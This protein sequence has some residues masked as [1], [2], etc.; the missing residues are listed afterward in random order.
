M[1]PIRR[2]LVW[3]VVARAAILGALVL[4]TL[5]LGRASPYVWPVS[6]LAVIV[7]GHSLIYAVALRLS[8]PA[9]I[10][11]PVQLGNDVLLVTWLVYHT[12]DLESP[13]LALYLIVIFAASLLSSRIGVFAITLFTIVLGSIVGAAILSGV[14]ARADGTYY[15]DEALPVL[16]LSFAYTVVA[17]IAVA[18]LSTHLAGRQRRSDTELAETVRSLADL[19]AF[20]ERVIE[21]MRS[22]LITAGLDGIIASTNK[23]AEEITGRP[24][25]ELVG[26]SIVELFGSLPMT[27]LVKNPDDPKIPVLRSELVFS[28]P[29]G[30][31]V[32]VGY[33]VT[34]LTAED[35]EVRGIVL[36]F[37]DL[38]EI[39]ELEQE[40][41]RR[42]KLAALGTM[43][44][45]L[46]HEIRNPLASMRGS[47][48][49]LAAEVPLDESQARLMN[50]IQRESDRLNRTVTAF[51]A[52]A[53]PAPF[54]A[55][56]F[57]L[58]QSLVEAVTL[59]RNS[60]EVG[61]K[62]T[63]VESYPAGEAPFYGDASQIRQIFWNLARNGLKAMPDGG[64]LTVRL[65]DE[66]PAAYRLTV[67]DAGVGM[68]EN[69]VAHLFEPF[70][71]SN[72]GGTGL[73]MAIVYQLVTEHGG[74][75]IVDSTK[76]G[77]TRM[78]VVLPKRSSAS[79]A[80]IET[81][82][83]PTVASSST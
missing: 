59:L 29:D 10:L 74:R 5:L 50:I 45:G 13:F 8:V 28:R 56:A 38:T 3:L 41:R 63:L 55:T 35:G 2:R 34:P 66:S 7:S 77:G 25:S 48:Q 39:F 44:A 54:R 9:R 49:V 80:E 37:Q 57:D 83:L 62:H 58:R 68:D 46:A 42:E 47:V 70:S 67:E 12:G 6:L 32:H 64:Q 76:G 20:N 72:S 33:N 23:A 11:I 61:P 1:N 65:D 31:E 73:G 18:A 81:S 14:V 26:R 79:L 43:A 75:I 71:A 78:H 27:V 60:P 51:L 69:Q 82:G 30:A 40:V 19:R 15:S 24:K 21:S 52:Y 53:R 36:I 4:L 22:G 17:T 16:Q